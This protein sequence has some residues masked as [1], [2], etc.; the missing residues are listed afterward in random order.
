MPLFRTLCWQLTF[1]LGALAVGSAQ[2][3]SQPYP[4]RPI[5][6]VVPY[7]AGGNADI[8][9]R[10]IAKK[11]GALLNV[12]VIVENRSGANGMI[13]TDAVVKAAA[14]GYTLLMAASGP[15]VINPVLYAKVPYDPVK[16]LLPISQVLSFQY[17]LVVPSS[18]ALNS[19]KEI[20]QQGKAQPGKLSYGSTGI[21][22][23]GHLAGEM[24]S[25]L[26]GSQF[27]H[28]PYKGSA[29]ALVDL[30]GG[31]LA[32]TFDTVLTASPL[33][34]DKRLRAFAV[35]GPQRARSLPNIPTMQE[36]GFKDFDI[37][38][39]VGLLAPA[40]TEPAMIQRLNAVTVQALQDPEV[41]E[42]LQTKGGNDLVGNSSAAFADLIKRELTMYGALIKRAEIKAE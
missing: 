13:G 14:D 2:A 19:L 21:G 26:S 1:A 37:T 32:F 42:A 6:M 8:T 33:I 10:V 15:I 28:V 36:A 3:Q 7:P 5:K 40:G 25:M 31:Q 22:G 35:S 34:Q 30:L 12:P 39:F 18:S 17:V 4:S 9:G 24:F 23:G 27:N 41:I 11:M 38:Q 29:P 16:D 20:V